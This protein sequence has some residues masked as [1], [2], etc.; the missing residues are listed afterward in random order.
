MPTTHCPISAYTKTNGLV[1]FARCLSKIRLH[2][3]SELREDFHE[4]LG[5]GFD[6][7]LCAYLRVDY[8]ALRERTLA[9]DT[10]EEVLAWCFTQGRDLNETDI[11]VWNDFLTKKG[12]N[13][14]VTASLAKRKA[15]SGLA[16]RSEIETMVEYFE[17]DEGRKS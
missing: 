4:Q 15:A 2:A 17:Y 10:D 13:D 6:G 7:R 8:S 1:Y 14:G 11:I 16:D 3:R 12:W 5:Q 9:G